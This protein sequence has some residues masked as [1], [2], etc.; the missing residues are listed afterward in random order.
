MTMD[1]TRHATTGAALLGLL[2]CATPAHPQATIGGEW[3]DDV[4]AFAR[5]LV[6]AGLTPGMAV[7]VS[8]SDWVLYSQGFGVADASTGRPVDDATAFYIAS[9]TKALTA[10]AVV[11]KA[12]NGAIDLDAPIDR[13]VPGLR[14]RPPMDAHRLTVK[15]FLTMTEGLDNLGPV[16]VR[17]AHTG[18]FTIPLLVRL[19]AD[20]GP[21]PDG[22][23]FSY[24][25]LPYNILGIAL[26]PASR[27]GWKEVVRR[28]VLEPLGMRA[29]SARVSTIDPSR[30]AL[31]HTLASGGTWRRERLTK[32][33]ET[34]HAAGGH[35]ATAQDLARFV[36]AH[37]SGGLLEGRRVFPRAAIESTH[38]KHADQDRTYGLFHRFGWGYGWDLGTYEGRTIV[39]R[40]GGFHGY[41]SHASFEP[42]SGVGV[43]V[44]VNGSGPASPA[45]D[46]MATYIYDRLRGRADLASEYDRRLADL[47]TRAEEGR[48]AMAD[49]LAKR[50]ARMAPLTRPLAAYAGTYEGAMFGTMIW[51]VVA[52]GLEVRMGVAAT[53]AEVFNAASDEFQV[54]LFGGESAVVAFEF[55][56]GDGPA[57][58]VRMYGER[59][60]RSREPAR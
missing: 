11:L 10:T 4:A 3:R 48:K 30:I 36:A 60:E 34:Q 7:A 26:D 43:V 31:P 19:L 23:A 38:E 25:N 50:A 27:E 24:G 18:D 55:P 9:T 14:F 51:R 22:A 56:A 20:C 40:F 39:H 13:Y 53:R 33:D 59:F 21:D 42:E 44:L 16:V 49:E 54:G 32:Q 58:A 15:Q 52:N 35:F 47:K 6:D 1:T 5:R 8:Q 2:L 17:T 45:A 37:A 28:D 29:T 12:A 46:V 41:K 57:L